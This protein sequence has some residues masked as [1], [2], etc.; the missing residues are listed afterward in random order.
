MYTASFHMPYVLPQSSPDRIPASDAMLCSLLGPFNAAV[1]LQKEIAGWIQ[2]SHMWSY[3]APVG[4]STEK[5]PWSGAPTL[6]LGRVRNSLGRKKNLTLAKLQNMVQEG[7]ECI[8]LVAS[9]YELF[10]KQKS[11]CRLATEHLMGQPNG[12]RIRNVG[13]YAGRSR[14]S[15][16]N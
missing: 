1:S 14:Y 6:P 13:F 15:F 5:F 9:K 10:Y 16:Q 11:D 4:S 7:H 2:N 3:G 12:P 8:Q